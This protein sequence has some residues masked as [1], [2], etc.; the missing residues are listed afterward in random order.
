MALLTKQ[1][2][3][4]EDIKTLCTNYK[5]DS[6][7]RKNVDYLEKRL[8]NLEQLWSVFEEQHNILVET[9]VHK[10]I[11]YFNDD[12]YTKTKN[13]YESTK[14][15][16]LDLM[17]SQNKQPKQDLNF[18]LSG[19]IEEETEEDVKKLITQQERNFKALTKAMSKINIDFI[20]ENWEFEEHLATLKAKWQSIDKIHWELDDELKGS[21]LKQNYNEK[22]ET[23]EQKYDNLKRNLNSK[24]WSKIHLQKSTPKIEIPEFTGKY[25]QWITFK[26]IFLETIHNNPSIPKAQKMQH[27][28][29]KLK[30]EAERLVQHLSI[31]A[32]N[33][34]SCW[35]ILSHRYDNR[36][37]QFTSFMS[38]MQ[39]LPTIQQ[40]NANNLKRMHDVI[41]ECLN[42]LGNM[43]VEVSGWGP[44]IVYMMSQK[45]DPTTLNE[46]TK[47][48]QNNRELPDLDEFLKF[49]ELSFLAHETAK[50]CLKDSGEN[51]TPHR[52]N[53]KSWSPN[54]KFKSN[55]KKPEDQTK[56]G[57]S[58]IFHASFGK[59]PLC[60]NEHVLMQCDKFINMDISQRNKTVA[61]LKLCKNCLFSH[62]N[63]N[64]NSRK[65]CREC[66]S[67]H[68]TLLHT[69]PADS[70]P[71]AER[72]DDSTNSRPSTSAHHVTTEYTEILLTTVLVKVKSADGTY[73]TLRGLNN[74]ECR[75]AIALTSKKT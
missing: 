32:D 67:K 57:H 43:G 65:T 29:T 7:T 5:K 50:S 16:I 19:L 59:C 26:D 66:N 10:N 55:F 15:H 31:S 36:R 69:K 39:H 73:V 62:G 17:A 60:N 38:T 47:E 9:T 41:T 42:G 24:I 4:F 75:S 46:Y 14:R 28:K 30:G 21:S 49:L 58:K 12:V 11:G 35:E 72:R 74:R 71:T 13:M 40:P 56:V 45:L 52:P 48:T 18:D 51:K 6:I 8:K 70:E 61:K 54:Y 68:H 53:N 44:M 20:T 1:V 27:L 63:N 34:D 37:L 23:I 2:G 3:I 25:V 33:Y 22:Y 64:C